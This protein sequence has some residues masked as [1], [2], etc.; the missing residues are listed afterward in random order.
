MT[1][2]IS[3][4]PGK[5]FVRHQTSRKLSAQICAGGYACS[6]AGSMNDKGSSCSIDALAF[7]SQ[8]RSASLSV[9]R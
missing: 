8:D 5:T 3:F 4:L 9:E 2:T 1:K 6:V 7:P